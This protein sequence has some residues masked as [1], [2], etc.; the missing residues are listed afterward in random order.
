MTKG[1]IEEKYK[2]SKLNKV[3]NYAVNI[4]TVLILIGGFLYLLTSLQAVFVLFAIGFIGLLLTI[5]IAMLLYVKRNYRT[6]N[7]KIFPIIEKTQ[8]KIEFYYFKVGRLLEIVFIIS[9]IILIPFAAIAVFYNNYLI[10]LPIVVG[11]FAIIIASFIFTVYFFIKKRELIIKDIKQSLWIVIATII[12]IILTGLGRI[13]K[14][15]TIFDYVILGVFAV[16]IY[17]VICWILSK[18]KEVNK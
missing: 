17:L 11:I 5:F 4:S 10:L 18:H 9:I 6:L 13:S 14:E 2:K 3:I 12:F 8:N 1:N 15:L 16:C 7:R